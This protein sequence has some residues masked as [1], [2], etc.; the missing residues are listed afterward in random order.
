M[1]FP[2]QYFFHHRNAVDLKQVL[3]EAYRIMD[4]TPDNIHPRNTLDDFKSLTTGQYPVF[5]KYPKFI[6]DYQV[7]SIML[8]K[9][10]CLFL[11]FRM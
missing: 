2:L 11:H 6:V 5:N 8:F 3:K 4:A 10:L 1:F 9:N 7:F